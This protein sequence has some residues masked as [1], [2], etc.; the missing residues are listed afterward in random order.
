L[1]DTC[2]SG[3]AAIDAAKVVT[4]LMANLP[5]PKPV[6]VGIL[7]SAQEYE[8]ARDGVFFAELRAGHSRISQRTRHPS[9][10]V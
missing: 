1:F 5:D 8:R 6:W 3:G 7:A 2:Y 10:C 9:E 4:R